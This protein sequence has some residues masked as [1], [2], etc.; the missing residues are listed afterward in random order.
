MSVHQLKCG[1]WI[2]K[3]YIP[4]AK[5]A[6]REYF[7]RGLEAEKRARERDIELN[8]P[9][10][11]RKTSYPKTP[12]FGTIAG[13]YLKSKSGIMSDSAH[14]ALFYKLR[15]VMLPEIGKTPIAQL[16]HYRLDQY[17][18]KRLKTVKKTTVHRELSDIQAILSWGVRRQYIARN[19]LVGYEKPK[20]DDAII[21]PPNI[22]EIRLILKYSPPHIRRALII[23]YFCGLRPGLA[24][25]LTLKWES[26]DFESKTILIISAKKQGPRFRII[27]LHS[28][29]LIFLKVWKKEDKDKKALEMVTYLDKPI[30]SIKKGFK[31]AKE[32]A[33]ITRRI[34]PY[35]FRHAFATTLLNEGADLKA[36]SEILGH[37]R[38][39][40]TT[41]IYQHTSIDIHRRTIAKIPPL[42]FLDKSDKT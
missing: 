38:T 4:G 42:N 34:R 3:Y 10:K 24:E 18:N 1:R 28:E 36:T 22:N 21:L 35:D 39:D 7:G 2:A 31:S 32:R 40:T 41:K 19:P 5:S 37:T 12:T 33:G 27:P 11:P 9:G 20:R 17:V 25:L 26:V 13:A 30:K 14:E 23:S 29:F 6:K 15:G 16:T 8:P